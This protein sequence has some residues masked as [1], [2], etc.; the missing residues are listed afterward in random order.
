MRNKNQNPTRMKTL[1]TSCLLTVSFIGNL[2]SQD[3]KVSLDQT[4]SR[5]FNSKIIGDKF[6]IQCYIPDQNITPTDSLP[7]VFVLDSDMSFGLTYDVVRWLNWGQEIP[8]MA[9]IGISYGTGQSDWW[10]K[11]SRDYLPSKD[12]T[13]VWGDWPLAGGGDN[14]KKFLELELFKFIKDEFNLKS[15]NRTIVGLSFGGLICTDILF[16][17]PELFNNYIILGP[18]LLWNNKEVLIKENK[19]FESHK[20]LNA[21]VFTAIGILD[22]KSIIEPWKEFVTQ[23]ESRKYSGL[24]F[25]KWIIDNETHLSMFPSGLTRGLKIVINTK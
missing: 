6:L 18:A 25:N 22:D 2:L 14:F 21:N 19:Y 7:I 24:T 8:P 17:N 16:S 9:I 5:W 10:K 12:Q 13:K 20:S 3:L 4:H 1:L 15:N 23:L 11:R